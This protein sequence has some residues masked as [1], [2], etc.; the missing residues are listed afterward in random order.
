MGTEG[1]Q[2]HGTPFYV[3]NSQQSTQKERAH[4]T[5]SDHWTPTKA[6]TTQKRKNAWWRVKS[7]TQ[8]ANRLETEEEESISNEVLNHVRTITTKIRATN[9]RTTQTW[10]Y[11]SGTMRTNSAKEEQRGAKHKDYGI[12]DNVREG[13]QVADRNTHA[14]WTIMVQKQCSTLRETTNQQRG[15]KEQIVQGWLCNKVTQLRRMKDTYLRVLS[16]ASVKP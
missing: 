13:H 7:A 1:E 14:R 11:A 5:A 3:H 8:E 12:E 6:G 9:K 15:N 16:V 2:T 4:S 10:Q